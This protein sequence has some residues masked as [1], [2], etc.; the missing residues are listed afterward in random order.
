MAYPSAQSLVLTSEW[1]SIYFTDTLI[2][3]KELTITK[4]YKGSIPYFHSG[5]TDYIKYYNMKLTTINYEGTED[6]LRNKLY[7]TSVFSEY[8]A[9]IEAGITINCN[10]TIN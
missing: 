10:Y 2:D 3:V 7:G 6:E 9:L 8:D 1:A 5:T 4:D